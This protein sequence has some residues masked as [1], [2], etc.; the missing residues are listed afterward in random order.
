MD[1]ETA[2][3]FPLLDLATFSS[4]PAAFFL[5]APRVRGALV[6]GAALPVMRSILC[7]SSRGT[8]L[9]NVL[10]AFEVPFRVGCA[11]GDLGCSVTSLKR[12]RCSV[13]A[14]CRTVRFSASRV[15]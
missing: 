4:E 9:W 1:S 3:S 12:M 8:T 15:R 6:T 11:V 2:L 10:S 7:T 14:T 5:P 13:F